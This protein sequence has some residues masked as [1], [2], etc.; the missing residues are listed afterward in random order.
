VWINFVFCVFTLWNGKLRMTNNTSALT[1]G[2]TF[3]H[4]VEYNEC[5]VTGLLYLLGEKF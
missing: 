4:Q 3:K 5:F 2:S 1:S